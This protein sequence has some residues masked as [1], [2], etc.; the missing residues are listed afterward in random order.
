MLDSLFCSGNLDGRTINGNQPETKPLFVWE[1][2]VEI[3]HHYPAQLYESIETKFFS[4]PGESACSDFP[5]RQVFGVKGLKEPF[6]F[7]L[8]GT[9]EEV[10]HEDDQSRESEKRFTAEVSF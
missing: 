9:F 10:H 6:Q 5:V 1:V 8:D 3:I 4:G 7:I 2:L